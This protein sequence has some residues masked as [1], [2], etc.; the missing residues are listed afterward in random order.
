MS[1]SVHS[2]LLIIVMSGITLMLRALPF[3][4]FREG[5]P[6][7]ATVIRLSKALPRAVMAMLVV[8]CLK[9]VSLFAWPFAI[10]ELIAIALVIATYVWKK[11]TLVSIL[12]GTIVYMVLVQMVF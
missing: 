7:P 9:D 8:Y 12:L 4:I 1:N 5:R 3:I 6:V 2:F 11:N 10:P